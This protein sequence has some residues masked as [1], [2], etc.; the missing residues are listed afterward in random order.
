MTLKGIAY[1]RW[2]AE[3]LREYPK[4][5]KYGIRNKK[6]KVFKRAATKYPDDELR[7]MLDLIDDTMQYKD[8][9]WEGRI[10]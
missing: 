8:I 2:G 7:R 5:G 9:H 6:Y 4:Y 1:L 10:F 3:A